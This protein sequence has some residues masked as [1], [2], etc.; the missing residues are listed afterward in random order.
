MKLRTKMLV[1]IL[2]TCLIVFSLVIGFV[3][4][5]S[6]NIAIDYAVQLA[7]KDAKEN[8]KYSEEILDEALS[9]A[10]TMAE[11]FKVMAST[12]W[13]NRDV[14][15][16][17][18]RSIL[19]NN[20]GFLGIWT[21]WE[22]NYFDGNDTAYAGT[23][24]HDSTGKF[25]PYWYRSGGSISFDR[26][27]DYDTPVAGDYYLLARDTGKEVVLE[28]F[29]YEIEGKAVL[30]TSLVVPIIMDGKSVGA[31][32]VDITLETLQ[33]MVSGIKVYE[34]GFGQ[35]LSH[36]GV[37]LAHPDGEKI[38]KA[39]QDLEEAQ[40]E[41]I[42]EAIKSGS[43]LSSD[44]ESYE[45]DDAE[46]KVFAPVN[47]GNTV[48]PWSF[49]IVV[50]LDEVLVES[51]RLFYTTLVAGIAGLLLLSLVVFLISKSIVAPIQGITR[52]LGLLAGN[53]FTKELASGYV[54]R[55]DEVGA[56]AKA[57]NNIIYSMKKVLGD[58]IESSQTVAAS[59]QQM[60]TSSEEASRVAE[61][62]STTIQELASG[63]SDQ[64]KAAQNGNLIVGELISGLHQITRNMEES[65]EFMSK[66]SENAKSGV[67]TVAYQ[68]TKMDESISATDKVSREVVV[69]SSKSNEIGQI[70]E[71]IRDIADQTNLLALNA[72]IEAAR[73]GDQGRGFAVVAE[74]VRKLAEESGSATQKIGLLIE[75]MQTNV[76]KV[77][78][79]MKITHAVVDQQKAAVD[80]TTATFD[81]IMQLIM[82]VT[83]QVQKVSK[84]AGLL[85]SKATATG[86][87]IE[88][89]AGVTEES[90]A[91]TEEA[92][93][94]SE[95]QT[96]AIQQITSSSEN[97]AEL[98]SKLQDVVNQFRI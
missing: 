2:T 7:E 64:A 97:L 19:E 72:A 75:E 89:I 47:A 3:S 29:T 37:V 11:S 17:M 85:R 83:D 51:N 84:D 93:A 27:Y 21:C 38:G 76:E 92:A 79:E 28:P 66:A 10:R 98:A 63:A 18:L 6:R 22:A 55:K 65:E 43:M 59:S 68:K 40:G 24:G 50:P 15:N 45:S 20:P 26:L 78:E 60:L 46:L 61:E 23:Y 81:N 74:E 58:I 35:L 82:D 67:E 9:I 53:D 87:E 49:A 30:M 71:V 41:S 42:I 52:H 16:E 14:S 25:I 91:S 96:A 1:L 8:A 4:I 80:E 62:I 44:N 94:S 70:I 90:A 32:G 33:E 34:T 36:E 54:N 13:A 69:L 77:A 57:V 56:M 5:N 12:G 95:E 88:N 31:V 39:L 48:T 86:E 73:A